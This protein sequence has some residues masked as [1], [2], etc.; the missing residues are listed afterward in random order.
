LIRLS[1]EIGRGPHRRI[2]TTSGGSEYSDSSAGG[3]QTDDLDLEPKMQRLGEVWL[4]LERMYAH[5]QVPEEKFGVELFVD[6]PGAVEWG[7]WRPTDD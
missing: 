6:Q 7:D 3:I 1:I 2:L 4:V 5:S